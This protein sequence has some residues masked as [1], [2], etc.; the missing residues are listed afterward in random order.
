M[1]SFSSSPGTST[2]CA[3][4]SAPIKYGISSSAHSSPGQGSQ[5]HQ[6][7]LPWWM[8]KG[9]DTSK[10]IRHTQSW[11]CSLDLPS[12][13]GDVFTPSWPCSCFPADPGDV[14]M[15]ISLRGCVLPAGGD[16][17]A[18]SPPVTPAEILGPT[19]LPLCQANHFMI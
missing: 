16:G 10:A 12:A 9:W 5:L 19:S 6:K 4:H 1:G 17:T 7:M 2:C 3:L 14:L 15:G 13:L 11:R 8:S 18:T